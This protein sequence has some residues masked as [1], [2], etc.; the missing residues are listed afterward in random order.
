MLVPA[1][2]ITGTF[3]PVIF[4][5][6][7]MGRLQLFSMDAVGAALGA[8][9]AFFVPM[10]FGF[11]VFTIVAMSVFLITGICMLAFLFFS[12]NA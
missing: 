9:L 12:R 11:Q 3:F 7:P 4:E 8:I 1:V 5:A 10:L 6:I 2:L